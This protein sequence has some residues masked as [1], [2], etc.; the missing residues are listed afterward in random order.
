MTDQPAP[1]SDVPRERFLAGFARQVGLTTARL[2]ETGTTVVP[3]PDRNGVAVC[4]WADRHA[5]VWTSPELADQLAGLSDRSATADRT[6]ISNAFAAVG[7]EHVADADMQVLADPTSVPSP[8]PLPADHRHRRLGTEPADV[9]LVRAFADR[10]DPVEVEEAA[11]DELDDFDERAINVVTPADNPDHLVAYGSAC[12]WD[13]DDAFTDI[14]VLVDASRRRVGL[15]HF[16][17]R[18]TVADL[19]GEGRMPLY[20]HDRANLGSAAIA[21]GTGFEPAVTLSFHSQSDQV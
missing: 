7:L 20:R 19:L 13:W 21:T 15:G 11:L 2:A 6:V 9:D 10:C 1:L 8:D 14:G 18:H 5:V 3:T 16:V 4:Y 12:D 17:V